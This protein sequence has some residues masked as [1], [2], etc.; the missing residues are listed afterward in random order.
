MPYNQIL[1]YENLTL[2]YASRFWNL[3]RIN[4]LRQT[5]DACDFSVIGSRRDAHKAVDEFVSSGIL[6]EVLFS[7]DIRFP[8]SL[9][10]QYLTDADGSVANL[11]SGLT[12][13]LSH[14][15]TNTPKDT[16]SVNGNG[17]DRVAL[18]RDVAEQDATKQFAELK[19]I[20]TG[21]R[22]MPLLLWNR[23][24]FETKVSGPWT[25]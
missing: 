12:T 19:K 14:R 11:F 1:N 4:E 20:L 23:R 18:V 5:L 17:S 6:G 2:M 24:S 25:P 21:L 3:R 9:S 16:E 8:E 22:T 15:A 10:D 13:I 7:V